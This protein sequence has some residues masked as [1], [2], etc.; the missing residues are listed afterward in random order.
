MA[1]YYFICPVGHEMD[2]NGPGYYLELR[3]SLV[4]PYT[5]GELKEITA[6]VQEDFLNLPTN[7]VD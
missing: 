4:G 2:W 1:E 3:G 5:S 7:S 6:I